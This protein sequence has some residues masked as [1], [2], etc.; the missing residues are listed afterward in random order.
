MIIVSGLKIFYDF[1]LREDFLPRPK[2]IVIQ[3]ERKIMVRQF[4][5]FNE[6]RINFIYIE[7]RRKYRIR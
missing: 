5:G 7:I 3:K 4:L 2:M 6:S 1:I